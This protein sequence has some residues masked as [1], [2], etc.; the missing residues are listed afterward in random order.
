[1]ARSTIA[2]K[3]EVLVAFGLDVCGPIYAVEGVAMLSKLSAVYIRR[4]LESSAFIRSLEPADSL[5]QPPSSLA[6]Q[7]AS[8]N[9]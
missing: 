3:F 4:P 1:M 6:L 8:E 7:S 9:V 2:S 5:L